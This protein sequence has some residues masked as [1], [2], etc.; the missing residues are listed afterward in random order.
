MINTK[1]VSKVLQHLEDEGWTELICER[2]REE[3]KN[4]IKKEFKDI[5]EDTL[6]YVLKVVLW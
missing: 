1:L 5:D 4:D 2:W 3:V 6:N